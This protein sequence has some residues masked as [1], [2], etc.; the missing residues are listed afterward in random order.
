MAVTRKPLSKKTRFEVFKRDGFSCQYCGEHPPKVILHVDHIDP[1]ALGGSNHIDNLITSCQPCN[2]GKSATPLSDIPQSL[3]DKA[4]LIIEREAQI[5]GYQRV[6]ND[7]KQRI[8]DEAD[9]VC[10]VYELFHSGYTLNEKAMIS[11]KKFVDSLGVHEV[12]EAME[13]ACCNTKIRKGT[14]FAYFCGICWN[15]IKRAI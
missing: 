3:Q 12:V 13:S 2:S 10:G 15:K 8:E 5:K 6:M 4:A 11:V 7:K 9:E 14:E 1:V